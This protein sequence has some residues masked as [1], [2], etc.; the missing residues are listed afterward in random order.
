MEATASYENLRMSIRFRSVGVWCVEAA[1]AVAQAAAAAAPSSSSSSSSSGYHSSSSEL[2]HM[3]HG[4]PKS[5]LSSCILD[6]L[7]LSVNNRGA[8]FQKLSKRQAADQALQKYEP[9]IVQ[10]KNFP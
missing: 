2:H 10:S 6:A 7:C 9:F 1:A 4:C 8:K 3:H 5:I